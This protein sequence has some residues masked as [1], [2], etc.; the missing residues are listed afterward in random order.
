VSDAFYK[1]TRFLALP[2]LCTT[3]RPVVLGLENVPRSGACL[4]AANHTSPYDVPVLI[5]HVP[6]PLDFVSIVEV[7][8]NPFVAWLY[9]NMN[10]F[11]LD[12]RKPDAPTVR[13]ILNRLERGRVVVMFPEGGFRRGEASVIRSRTMRPGLGRIANIAAVPVVP[14]VLI[15]TSVY[16]K[17]GSWLPFFRTRYAIAFAPPISPQGSPEETDAAVIEAFVRLYAQAVAKLPE[18]CRTL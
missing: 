5:R 17:P 18:H 10:A 8:Q 13:K 6:R 1:A 3:S 16:A 14:A 7:F 12:R 4:I 15:N 11:A 2:V 9:G